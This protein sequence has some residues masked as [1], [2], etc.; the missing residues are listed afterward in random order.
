MLERLTKNSVTEQRFSDASYY[1]WNLS[2]QC[3]EIA[4]GLPSELSG[5]FVRILPVRLSTEEG[6][7]AEEVPR[8]SKQG[9]RIL[10]L[11]FHSQIHGLGFPVVYIWIEFCC[12]KSRSRL[13]F[14]RLTSTCLDTFCTTSCS[15]NPSKAFLKCILLFWY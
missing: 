13:T 12:R 3:L 6:R 11:S 14:P 10:R 15:V 8:I 5:C 1:Y 2:I 4:K 9:R 7:D